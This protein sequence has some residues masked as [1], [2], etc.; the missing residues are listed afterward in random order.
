MPDSTDPLVKE[1]NK[2]Y[3]EALAR[4]SPITYLQERDF[5]DDL[6]NT[7]A[8]FYYL[9]A[10]WMQQDPESF[11]ELKEEEHT[12]V[13]E[14]DII[15]ALNQIVHD[16]DNK[17]NQLIQQI[18][19]W[20]KKLETSSIT[21]K[22]AIQAHLAE[23]KN[24]NETDIPAFKIDN[25]EKSAS[26][27]LEKQKKIIELQK[28]TV[29]LEQEDSALEVLFESQGISDFLISINVAT[30]KDYASRQVI[31][32]STPKEAPIFKNDLVVKSESRK[33]QQANS[34]IDSEKSYLVEDDL[35]RVSKTNIAGQSVIGTESSNY[36][37]YLNG[38]LINREGLQKERDNNPLFDRALKYYDSGMQSSADAFLKNATYKTFIA[39]KTILRFNQHKNVMYF[40]SEVQDSEVPFGT[41]E[42][43]KEYKETIATPGMKR[44]KMAG[45]KVVPGKTISVYKFND[46]VNSD[47][48]NFEWIGLFASNSLLSNMLNAKEGAYQNLTDEQI[49]QAQKEECISALLSLR[50][51]IKNLQPPMAQTLLY[52]MCNMI[53]QTKDRPDANLELLTELSKTTK[54]Y[55]DD[56]TNTKKATKFFELAPKIEKEYDASGKKMAYL[57]VGLF[58]TLSI[59]AIIFTGG[60]AELLLVATM[61]ELAAEALV[62]VAGILM[63]VGAVATGAYTYD[64]NRH[65]TLLYQNLIDTKSIE[66]QIEAVPQQKQQN[67]K[68]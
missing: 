50:N 35:F 21:S 36:F 11:E 52:S 15:K 31:N 12:F 51:S 49:R 10:N 17:K 2:K 1:Q 7:A 23:I 42:M 45:D 47:Q 8:P 41:D 27:I 34:D 60:I 16:L 6:K 22:Q 63:G 26:I 14:D 61:G 13:S 39:G 64:K 68:N 43:K 30:L 55:I 62:T 48:S 19:Y 18:S 54:E 59:L 9:L 57:M 29:Q 58:I 56:P 53:D 38:K 37:V 20:E 44:K 32:D 3:N 25:T 24:I 4:L 5:A 66:K 46:K 40:S 33:K 67:K 28:N 65:M